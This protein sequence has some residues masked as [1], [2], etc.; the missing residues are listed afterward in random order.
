MSQ[1][2]DKFFGWVDKVVE[3]SSQIVCY[4][5]F[6]IMAITAIDVTARYV[7][8]NPLLWGWL[9]NRLL[10]GVFILFAG[11]YTLSR[12]EHIRIEII[13]DHFPPR[14]KSD[15]MK[16]S[17]LCYRCRLFRCRS[18][19]DCVRYA[20]SAASPSADVAPPQQNLTHGFS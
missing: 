7:F 4:L 20:S 16:V 12:G 10:F 15:A 2:V 3:R 9:L 17:C 11:V 8:N 14:I 6:V 1:I 19:E 18:S 13:Y 5:V